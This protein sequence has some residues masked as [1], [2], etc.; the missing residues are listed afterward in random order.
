[1]TIHQNEYSILTSCSGSDIED[2]GDE[3]DIDPDWFSDCRGTTFKTI[4]QLEDRKD[5]IPVHCMEQYILDVQISVLEGALSKYKNLIDKGYDKK[6]QIYEKFVKDQ[7]PDQIN[8][9]MATDK[10]D[11]YFKCTEYKKGTCCDDCKYATCY[12]TCVHGKPCK[13]GYSDFAMDKCPKMEFEDKGIGSASIPNATFPLEDIRGFYDD[14]AETWGIDKSWIQFDRR[15]M[16]TNNGCQYA[17]EKVL[18][19]LDKNDNFFYQYPLPNSD[20]IEIYNPKEIIGD[21]YPKASDMLDRFKVVQQFGEYDEQD[22]LSDYVDATSLP[23][24]SIEEAVASMEKI[25]EKAD[26]IKKQ[27][28]EEFILN[29]ITGL[30]FYIPVVGEAAGAAGLTAARSLLRLIGAA[31]DLAITLHDVIENPDNAFL[32]V[33]TYLAGAGVGRGG[34]R[35]AA[36][37]RRGINKKDYDSLGNVKTNLDKMQS[38]RGNICGI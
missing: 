18:E 10:V 24:F 5:S 26:E 2:D 25:I 38:L 27:E 8:S 11:K 34:F 9:F 21:S 6:V 23:A 1:M 36:N 17:G 22:V 31:G 7:I 4:H 30:L 29:F 35:N 3:E 20:K 37:A 13:S 32:A 28:R 16:R 19:C 12:P 15:H 14:L 33:F